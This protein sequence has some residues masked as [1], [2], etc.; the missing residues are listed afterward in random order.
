[1]DSASPETF[2]DL[3][4]PGPVL[5]IQLLRLFRLLEVPGMRKIMAF[6]VPIGQTCRVHACRSAWAPLGELA[7]QVQ[8]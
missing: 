5:M 7:S 1:M 6:E 3:R 8:E 2:P 4:D